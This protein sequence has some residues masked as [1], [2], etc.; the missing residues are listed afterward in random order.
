[1][2]SKVSLVQLLREAADRQQQVAVTRAAQG[3]AV[4]TYK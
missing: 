2:Y 3:H 1:M 4:H